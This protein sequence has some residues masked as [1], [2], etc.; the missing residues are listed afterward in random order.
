MKL[1]VMLLCATPTSSALMSLAPRRQL[2]TINT[3]PA[4]FVVTMIKVTI[5]DDMSGGVCVD[6]C[7]SERRLCEGSVIVILHYCNR[8]IA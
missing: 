6:L 5:G 7:V 4:A 2:H 8:H 1:E 3:A